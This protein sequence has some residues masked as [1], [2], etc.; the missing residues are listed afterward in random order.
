MRHEHAAL[1]DAEA[2]LLPVERDGGQL[3]R[4]R[5][6]KTTGDG[7]DVAVEISVEGRVSFEKLEERR[8]SSSLSEGDVYV[9]LVH[10]WELHEDNLLL[11][12]LESTLK[13]AKV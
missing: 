10:A 6:V 4:L 13:A 1:K 8:K 7:E 9:A 2:A 5:V 12:G 3:V 11:L